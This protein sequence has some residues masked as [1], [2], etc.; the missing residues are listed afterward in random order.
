MVPVIK[1]SVST[2]RKDPICPNTTV[3]NGLLYFFHDSQGNSE[4]RWVFSDDKAKCLE[5]P[6][7]EITTLRNA[8][9]L[10]KMLLPDNSCQMV[11]VEE[12]RRNGTMQNK[13]VC[14]VTNYGQKER[15]LQILHCV[16]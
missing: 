2:I 10:K 5:V 3:V 14:T 15:I 7:P 16:P 1:K 4:K 12:F 8:S 9:L 11:E 13:N 6:W